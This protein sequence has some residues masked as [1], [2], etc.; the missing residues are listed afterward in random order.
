M[1]NWIFFEPLTSPILSKEMGKAS[2][3]LACNQTLSPLGMVVDLQ[4]VAAWKSSRPRG[5]DVVPGSGPTLNS[6]SCSIQK[7]IWRTERQ[8]AEALGAEKEVWWA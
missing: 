1:G 3:R 2:D 5:W 6:T 7:S 8:P 4:L